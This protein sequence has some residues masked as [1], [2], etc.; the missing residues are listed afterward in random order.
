MSHSSFGTVLF[1]FLV[2]TELAGCLSRSP[3]NNSDVLRGGDVLPG[4]GN[5]SEPG[6]DDAGQTV[7][8]SEDPSSM[9]SP[10]SRRANAMFQFLVAQ[11]KVHQQDLPGAEA[12]FESSYNLDPNSFTGARLVRSKIMSNPKSPEGLTEARRMSLLYPNDADLRLLYGQ[13]LLM[14][15][16]TKEAEVQILK[17]IELRPMLEDAYTALVK[18]YQM[19]NKIEAALGVARK[20]VK[21]NPQS[22]QGWSMLSRILISEKRSKEAIEPAR[23]AWELQ[24]NNPE[25]A[26]LYALTLDLN[27][28]S[29][30]AVNLYEQLYRFNPGNNELVQRMLLLYKEL[31][32]LSTALTLIDDMIDNSRGEVPGLKMQKVLILWEMN[33]NDEALKV[34]LSLVEELPESD[35][36]MYTVG[37]ALVIVGRAEEAIKYFVKIPDESAMK[38][39]AMTSQAVALRSLGK[40][41]EAVAVA[42]A[43]CSRAEA[44]PEA[45]QLW[46]TL[47][48]G[49]DRGSEAIEVMNQAIK[50]FPEDE[51]LLFDKGV[52]QEK[53]G[54]R[55][56]CEQT[57]RLVIEKNPKDAGALNFV[58]YMMAEDGRQLEEA[59]AFVHR[60]L[61]L[62]PKNGGYLDTLGWIYFQKKKFKM[63]LETFEKALVLDPDEGVIWEHAGDTL[64][65]LGNSK[66]ASEK[67]A[68][69][70]KCKSDPKDSA[71]FQKKLEAII[72]TKVPGG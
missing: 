51:A 3:K 34:A 58:A 56:G 65:A 19:Q 47:L 23:R 18:C 70:L 4:V 55:S 67:Y 32:S 31:G 52:Y 53:V 1:C 46:A 16:Q 9:W 24:E 30:E 7:G 62:R 29:S 27:K 49:Q 28:R 8:S 5:G 45:F 15:E 22:I 72:P 17:A 25:L 50:R 12:Y 6:M 69:A 68:A 39:D 43:L 21:A 37:V 48:I 13:V 42:K 20:L 10:A 57:M 36:A 66:G 71:R 44:R 14:A 59:E 40:I 35:R 54:D 61:A 41:E 11:K 2:L 60:A 26:L 63:A 33:R 38:M 64:L